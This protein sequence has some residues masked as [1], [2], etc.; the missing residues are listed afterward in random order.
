M[1]SICA[2]AAKEILQLSTALIHH[3]IAADN[4]VNGLGK[5]LIL[6]DWD[7]MGMSHCIVLIC[8]LGFFESLHGM[9]IPARSMKIF[10]R[11][12]AMGWS[13]E[14]IDQEKKRA[15]EKHDHELDEYHCTLLKS[16]SKEMLDKMLLTWDLRNWPKSNSFLRKLLVHVQFSDRV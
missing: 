7:R 5:P 10:S 2:E 15:R 12:V 3:D 9:K 11:L 1:P 6:P 8:I 13:Q 14:D 4:T 16:E